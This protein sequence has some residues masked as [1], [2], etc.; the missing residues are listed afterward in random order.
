LYPGPAPNRGKKNVKA[1]TTI[2]GGVILKTLAKINAGVLNFLESP[3]VIFQVTYVVSNPEIK[4]NVST[5][6]VPLKIQ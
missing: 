4:K 3:S 1:T 5:A 2:R 6:R